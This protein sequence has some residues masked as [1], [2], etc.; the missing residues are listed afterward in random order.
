M[1]II[2]NTI[3]SSTTTTINNMTT[4]ITSCTVKSNNGHQMLTCHLHQY[5]T[6][7]C[8]KC[9]VDVSIFAHEAHC[10]HA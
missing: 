7:F 10:P 1:H 6:E 4:T 2:D 8:P 9:G 5:N 3:V